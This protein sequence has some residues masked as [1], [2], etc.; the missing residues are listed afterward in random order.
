MARQIDETMGHRRRAFAAAE[1]RVP[2]KTAGGRAGPAKSCGDVRGGPSEVGDGLVTD[3]GVPVDSAE[4]SFC[5]G[6]AGGGEYC[7]RVRTAS[8]A[9]SGLSESREGMR[10]GRC[11]KGDPSRSGEAGVRWEV[12]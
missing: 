11:S 6:P 4:L 1:P 8:G 3:V 12:V 5:W 7:R 10:L 9:D 2:G